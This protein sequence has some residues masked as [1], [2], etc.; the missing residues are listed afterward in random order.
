MN[1]KEVR[2][3]FKHFEKG[4]RKHGM[5]SALPLFVIKHESGFET[6]VPQ[7]NEIL[8]LPSDDY[9]SNGMSS[10]QTALTETLFTAYAAAG[11]VSSVLMIGVGCKGIVP[12]D[13]EPTHVVMREQTIGSTIVWFGKIKQG[14]KISI[15]E[16]EFTDNYDD[17]F[18]PAVID[19]VLRLL[20]QTEKENATIN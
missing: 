5:A 19:Q 11:P 14:K 7:V 16:P 1:I 20:L 10:K 15:G 8:Q 13:T 2:T 6:I 12:E 9:L 18:I 17:G 3:I 4:V